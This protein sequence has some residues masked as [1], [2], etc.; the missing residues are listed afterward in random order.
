MAA[1]SPSPR[2]S[3]PARRRRRD[4]PAP[5]GSGLEPAWKAAALWLAQRRTDG[6]RR[7]S[8][9]LARTP[10]GACLRGR[11]TQRCSV[12]HGAPLRAPAGVSG[13]GVCTYIIG[14]RR[15]GVL[16]RGQDRV[17][18]RATRR[19]RRQAGDC[20]AILS[21]RSAPLGVQLASWLLRLSAPRHIV[22][23]TPPPIRPGALDRRE[24]SAAA[25]VACARPDGLH[26][27]LPPE[28]DA[29]RNAC[30]PQI[31]RARPLSPTST[32]GAGAHVGDAGDARARRQECCADQSD[33][34]IDRAPSRRRN[35]GRLDGR[36]LGLDRE[37]R[38]WHTGRRSS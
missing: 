13:P 35:G 10:R 34:D 14:E 9:F 1:S 31:R 7:A 11:R 12:Q 36:N 23:P 25:P 20:A 24:R 5:T 33:G 4:T 3:A 32:P 27:R 28:A 16:C 2:P 26:R 29:R 30:D 15:G 37:A 6:S 18:R 21:K 19:S 8:D 22:V 38:R 17:D